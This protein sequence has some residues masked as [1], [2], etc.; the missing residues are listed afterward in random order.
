MRINETQASDNRLWTY[1]AHVHFRKYMKKE[2]KIDFTNA[3]VRGRMPLNKGE[4]I[5]IIG[6][7]SEGNI[8][9]AE[10]IRPW[11]GGRMRSNER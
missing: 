11:G 1:L 3:L 10:E 6:K 4:K 2:W 9:V 8:F 5:K 7:I